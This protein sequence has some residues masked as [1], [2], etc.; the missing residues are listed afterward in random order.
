MILRFVKSRLLQRIVAFGAFGGCG[1]RVAVPS[2]AKYDVSVLGIP[3]A[4][5]GVPVRKF[6]V[7]ARIL[8]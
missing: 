7:L 8:R 6:L 5:G 3:L 1:S 4:G 2:M